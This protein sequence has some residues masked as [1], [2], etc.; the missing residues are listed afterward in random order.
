MLIMSAIIILATLLLERSTVLPVLWVML[1]IK[2][3]L[4]WVERVI[5]ILLLREVLLIM[6][7][8]GIGHNV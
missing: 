8:I 6:L 1:L 3:T 2:L 5:C 4:L 7:N